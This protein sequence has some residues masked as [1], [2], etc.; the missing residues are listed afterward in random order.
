MEATP[1]V[2]DVGI[3]WALNSDSMRDIYKRSSGIE[4]FLEH[5]GQDIKENDGNEISN[6]KGVGGKHA[7]KLNLAMRGTE[8]VSFGLANQYCKFSTPYQIH[9]C[10]GNTRTLRLDISP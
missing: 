1:M 5:M 7:F 9:K 2:T 3:C 4:T 8:Y 6:I 10:I